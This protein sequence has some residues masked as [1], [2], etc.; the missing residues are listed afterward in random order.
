MAIDFPDSPSANDA[1]TVSGRT[2]IYDGEKWNVATTISSSTD[3]NSIVVS[4]SAPL[5][6]GSGTLW[7]NSSNGKTYTYYTDSTS[8]Q[9]VEVGNADPT[10]SAL[11][12]KGDILTRSSSAMTR[13]GVGSNHRVLTADSSA[14][15][16]FKWSESPQVA[17]N[18]AGRPSS[19]YEGQMIYQADTNQVL[20]W[21]GSAWIAVFDTDAPPALSLVKSQTVGSGVGSV[22][23]TNCFNGDFDAYRAVYSGGVGSAAGT[24]SL[25]IGSVTSGYYMGLVYGDPTAGPAWGY[26]NNIDTSFIWGG[27]ATTQSANFD[28][29]FY[30]PAVAN[31]QT[32]VRVNFYRNQTT[33]GMGFGFID[34]LSAHSSFTLLVNGFTI[35]GGVI[36]V[37]GY[38]RAV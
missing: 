22:D 7:Y 34:N 13:L 15:E 6:P 4:D 23:V 36:N 37:Y 38:R 30:D 20:A 26:R 35:S 21:D 1:Y 14:A 19:P 9:W 33:L 11:T 31:R 28:I 29:D 25:R 10:F 3:P 16:G 2:W 5:A 24:F 18:T 27:G 32:S 17:A 12:T 8:S